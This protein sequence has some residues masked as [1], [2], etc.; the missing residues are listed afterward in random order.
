VSATRAADVVV[1]GAGMAGVAVAY[2]LAVR[3]GVARVVL[4]DPREPLSLTSDKGT[5]A[6]RDHWPGPDDAMAR[7]MERSIDLLEALDRDS[8]GAFGLN[9]R[10]YVFLTADPAEADRLRRHDGPS[11]RFEDD[12]DAIGRRYPFLTDRVAG[13]LQVP[14]AG[15]M[16][17]ARLGRW[18]LAGARRRGVEL[19]RDE[20]ADLVLEGGRLAGVRL[21]SGGR[22]DAGAAVLAVGP[23]LPRWTDRLG[24]GVPIVNE[25]H[26]K[27]AFEDEAG[28]VPR[29]APL[30]IWNDA[31]ELDGFGTFPPA[32]HVRPRGAA[33]LLGIWTY[34]ARLEEPAFP[35]AFAPDYAAIVMRGLAVMIPALARYAGNAARAVVD[36]GYY[37][38]APDNR[39]LAGP[40]AVPGVFVLGALSGFGI[41][42][43]QG[44]A[45]LLAAYILGEPLPGYAA[46]FHPSRFADAAYRR[47][48]TAR[49]LRSGQL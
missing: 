22:I 8:G 24:L 20:I 30:L 46:A 42:A 17:A 11:A 12:R 39:P 25:L 2:H 3:A 34:E 31:V 43:S 27:I 41:M 28:V 38:K 40:T 15:F 4:V 6:Y 36:G 19:L 5:E 9:R 45:E 10:G 16:D 18:L 21:S 48:L 7:L 35:P 32:V 44:T 37:C 49:D 1:A 47:S 14:R 33:T 29:D 26:G 23:L 13:M